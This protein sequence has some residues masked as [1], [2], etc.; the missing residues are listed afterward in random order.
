MMYY[1]DPNRSFQ[2]LNINTKTILD[3]DFGAASVLI[4][5]GGIVGKASLFQ[6][7]GMASIQIFFY[8]LNKAIIEYA[9]KASDY[10]GSM[11]I[12][13]FGAY[14]GLVCIWFYQPKPA[15]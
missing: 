11:V 5:M 6:L 2:K 7:F 13:V 10:G 3:A 9:F 15:I 12:H 8:T 14:F 1:D 4:T